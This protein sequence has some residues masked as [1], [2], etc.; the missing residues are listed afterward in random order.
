MNPSTNQ[1]TDK[2]RNTLGEMPPLSQWK[3]EQRRKLYLVIS[4]IL[5]IG[6]FI[7]VYHLRPLPGMT[8]SFSLFQLLV[9][10]TEYYIDDEGQALYLIYLMAPVVMALLAYRWKSRDLFRFSVIPSAL[11]LVLFFATRHV[12]MEE[13]YQK[14]F[15]LTFFGYLYL[16]L[17]A[18]AVAVSV[19]ELV[20]LF[21][22]KGSK[23]AGMPSE[24]P[25]AGMRPV[26]QIYQP[27]QQTPAMRPNPDVAP[28]TATAKSQPRFCAAC[29]TALRPGM[30]FCPKCGTPVRGAQ[31]NAPDVL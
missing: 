6:F 25:Y 19:W 16:I 10:P 29:G 28:Q 31:G 11:Y 30:R 18:L 20:A 5:C 8:E 4:V 23:P 14:Y 3:T 17:L 15:G 27:A 26:P 24:A 21:N 9:D 13:R 2:L 1:A 7:P 22:S 12:A